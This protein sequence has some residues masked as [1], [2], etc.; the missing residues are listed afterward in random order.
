MPGVNACLS[1]ASASGDVEQNQHG[2]FVDQP[3]GGIGIAVN[4]GP[5]EQTLARKDC[6]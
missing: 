4:I 5:T 2:G 1:S 6:A 3:F